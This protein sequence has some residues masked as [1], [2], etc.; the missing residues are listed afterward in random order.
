LAAIPAAFGFD[1]L[2]PASPLQPSGNGMGRDVFIET[3]FRLTFG[4][5]PTQQEL[6]RL[7]KA[8]LR[9]A[10]PHIVALGLWDSPE[11]RALEREGLA[12]KIGK[13]KAFER[14]LAAGHRAAKGL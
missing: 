3:F 10:T 4:R 9:G 2:D 14:A 11:H 5:D 12:P 7:T 8:L 13:H 6:D 1:G